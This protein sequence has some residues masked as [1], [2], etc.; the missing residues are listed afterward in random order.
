[1]AR[2]RPPVELN[3]EHPLVQAE[4]SFHLNMLA[5]IDIRQQ[6]NTARSKDGNYKSVEAMMEG[7]EKLRASHAGLTFA[8]ERLKQTWMELRTAM[9][10]ARNNRII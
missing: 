4:A 3:A 8:E 1:M 9:T 2:G 5:L 6:Y 10:V 7:R